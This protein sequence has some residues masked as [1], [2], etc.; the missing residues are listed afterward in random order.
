M[1]K[2]HVLF[3]S[4][5]FGIRCSCIHLRNIWIKF[6]CINLWLQYSVPKLIPNLISRNKKKK[7][8]FVVSPFLSF[9]QPTCTSVPENMFP[10]SFL[11]E[12]V[13]DWNNHFV[14]RQRY[15][16]WEGEMTPH[17]PKQSIFHIHVTVGTRSQHQN[18]TS[19]L[20]D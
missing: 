16:K 15:T 18:I 17:L 20:L 12:F 10:V 3:Q 2:N 9:H 7:M 8:L 19:N 4:R 11:M 13:E 14:Y 6:F 1:A 5:Q